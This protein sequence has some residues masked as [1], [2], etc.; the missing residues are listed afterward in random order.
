MNNEKEYDLGNI[1][2]VNTTGKISRALHFDTAKLIVVRTLEYA[3]L[4]EEQL[5]AR[6]EYIQVT[7]LN[8]TLLE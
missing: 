2:T 6:L 8:L 1:I 7:K 4:S 3:S 5:Q